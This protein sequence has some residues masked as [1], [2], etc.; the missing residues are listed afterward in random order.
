MKNMLLTD[1]ETIIM[2]AIWAKGGYVSMKELVASLRDDF[3]RDYA[4][5]TVTTFLGKLACKE[6]ICTERKGRNSYVRALASRKECLLAEFEHLSKIW[7]FDQTESLSAVVK[8][9]DGSVRC[10]QTVTNADIV[11]LPWRPD[12]HALEVAPELHL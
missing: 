11:D 2:N 8:T 7:N 3:G 9:A 4:R 5:T 10:F 12:R 6:L 1:S